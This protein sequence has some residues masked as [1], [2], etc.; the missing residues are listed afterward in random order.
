MQ[1]K[2]LLDSLD[3]CGHPFGSIKVI[4]TYSNDW[5]K[6]GYDLVDVCKTEEI[7]LKENTLNAMTEEYTCFMVDDLVVFNR[8][9]KPPI[10]AK[11]EVWSYRLGDNVSKHRDYPMSVDGH[12]FHTET[13]KPLVESIEFDNPNTFEKGLQQ[14]K[15]QFLT[16]WGNQCIVGVPHNRVSVKSH[17]SFSGEYTEDYLN[18]LFISGLTIDYKNMDFSDIRDVHKEIPLKFKRWQ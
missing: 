16:L 5:F 6:L 12:V 1:L 10:I 4:Y 13:L 9:P 2:A 15:N 3:E 11:D 17:C 18:D 8:V 14:Y 7:N